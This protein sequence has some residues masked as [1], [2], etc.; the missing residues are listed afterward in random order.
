MDKP[1]LDKIMNDYTLK[2]KC[3]HND[4]MNVGVLVCLKYTAESSKCAGCDY[5]K[6]IQEKKKNG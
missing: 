3:I 2:N 1:E 6:R 4:Y 5:E